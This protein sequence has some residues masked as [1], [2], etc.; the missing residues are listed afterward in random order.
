MMLF[1]LCR[2][3]RRLVKEAGMSYKYLADK[4]NKYSPPQ[5]IQCHNKINWFW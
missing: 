5:V 2:E 1:M 3:C 4:K